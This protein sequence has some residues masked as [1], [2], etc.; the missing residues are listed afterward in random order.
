[1][2]YTWA[3][4]NPHLPA[5]ARRLKEMRE[6]PGQAPRTTKVRRIKEVMISAQ[7]VFSKRRLGKRKKIT[8]LGLFLKRFSSF[9][10]AI[11]IKNFARFF[12][13]RQLTATPV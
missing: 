10:D 1:M 6:E 3:K 7:E 11:S 9:I 13:L 12:I 5:S 8:F 4:V 2:D